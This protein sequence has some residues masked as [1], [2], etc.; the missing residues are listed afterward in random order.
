MMDRDLRT[1]L[2]SPKVATVDRCLAASQYCGLRWNADFWRV[3][4]RALWPRNSSQG[5]EEQHAPRPGDGP[6]AAL[7]QR[8]DLAMDS[9]DYADFQ[10]AKLHFHESRVSAGGDVRKRLVSYRL[11]LDQRDE[12]VRMLLEGSSPDCPG[13][14]E[15]LLTACLVSMAGVEGGD[16]PP[17]VNSTSKL[18]ATNLIAEGRLWEG[19]Q[20]LCLIG[21]VA[22]ACS[23]LQASGEW[24]AS[25]WLA[26]CRLAADDPEAFA[27]VL[28]KYVD[29]HQPP[30]ARRLKAVLILLV[31]GDFVGVLDQLLGAKMVPLAAQFLQVC[32]EARVLPDTSHVVV[33]TEEIR[34][35]YA[36]YLFDCGNV[37]AAFHYCDQADEKGAVLR[38]EFE[39]LTSV[40]EETPAAIVGGDLAESR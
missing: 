13:Y 7:S 3:A 5:H 9:A 15:D 33:I 22:D 16:P 27:K 10:K 14:Y 12:A 38:H 19:V 4:S 21:K 26:K 1:Y 28:G 23:Y 17:A 32:E 36:R 24:D 34:L 29:H 39:V 20:L 8:F 35:A 37:P 25:L 18:V 2:C 40:T 31:S 11:C 30:D 6:A